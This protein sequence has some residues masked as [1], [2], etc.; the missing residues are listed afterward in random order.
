MS[1]AVDPN[2][3][4]ADL[5]TL[6][7]FG[8]LGSGVE[9]LAF[10]PEDRAA[11]EWLCRRMVDA[12]LEAGI[13]GIGTVYGRWPGVSRAV[14]TGSHSDTTTQGGWLDGALGVV[15]GLE[16]V[17]ALRGAGP[18]GPVGIDLVSFADEEGRFRGTLGS[19][20]FC[21]VLDPGEL[22][23]MR[24]LDGHSL[25]DALEECGYAGREMRRLDRDRIVAYVELHI[26]Q[27]PR[28]E[29][30][31]IPIGVVTDIVSMR[32]CGITFLGRAD[33]AGTTPMDMRRDAGAAAVRF[34]QTMADAFERM[35]RPGTVWNFGNVTMAPGAGNVVPRRADVLLEYRDSDDEFLEQLDAVVRKAAADAAMQAHVSFEIRPMVHM[36]GCRLSPAV[37]DTIEAAAGGAGAAS[38]RLSS[39]AGH[40]AMVVGRHVPSGML[41]VPSIEGR[42]HDPSE[43]T[44]DDDL[45]VGVQ[46]LTRTLARV[47]ATS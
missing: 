11:R 23:Q 5:N 21:G 35:R 27:G 3:F 25:A 39:G 6:R 16:A 18:D 36:P 38:M 28:L 12:G 45:V 2:R 4:L 17:R 1:T 32:R 15:A 40:D 10:T 19:S 44:D 22:T 37:V 13:D 9:R 34:L 42:S 24:D 47:A 20:V 46:V 14:L 26:E 29:A 41:F 7:Q 43:N 30:A 8:R 31:G 33:H